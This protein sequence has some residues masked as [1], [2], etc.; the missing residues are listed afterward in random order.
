MSWLTP[1]GFL[2]L[3]GLI[4]LILIYII[5]PNYQQKFISSTYVWVKS[6]KYKKKKMPIN[7]LQDILLFLCQV[8]IITGM[9]AILAQPFIMADKEQEVKEH[10]IIIDASASMLS[11]SYP[12]P[13][14][15]CREWV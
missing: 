1:L 14:R 15:P 9:A 11:T 12:A 4:V 3:I 2:G 7:R 13:H 8:L 10:V 6:L 5:K